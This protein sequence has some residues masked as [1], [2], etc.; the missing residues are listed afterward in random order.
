MKTRILKITL[1]AVLGVAMVQAAVG[2]QGSGLKSEDL[3]PKPAEKISYKEP[4]HTGMNTNKSKA[5]P[6]N[7]S[8]VKSKK[9]GGDKSGQ[10]SKKKGNVEMNW[11][12]EEGRK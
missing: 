5:K 11:K 7:P 6:N 4:A 8:D 10:G 9:N 12:V 2:G 3:K 1:A